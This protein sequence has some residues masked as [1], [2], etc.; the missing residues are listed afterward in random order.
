LGFKS[1]KEIKEQIKFAACK[2]ENCL[3]WDE[4][5]DFFFLKER[6]L[7]DRLDTS[8]HW[9][10]KIDAPEEEGEKDPEDESLEK[11]LDFDG[12]RYSGKYDF[13][14]EKKEVKMTPAL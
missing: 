8:A 12:P 13:Q 14:A 2:K 7:S 11:K 4:F 1:I 3:I 5:C 10:R 9:W 6:G